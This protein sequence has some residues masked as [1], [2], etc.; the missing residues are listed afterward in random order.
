MRTAVEWIITIIAAIIIYIGFLFLLPIGAYADEYVIKFYKGGQAV[1]IEYNGVIHAFGRGEP[2]KDI[3][4][5]SYI[6]SDEDCDIAITH[7][8]DTDDGAGT[9]LTVHPLDVG[10]DRLNRSTQNTNFLAW[11]HRF[12]F[13]I[14][15]STT[16]KGMRPIGWGYQYRI[17]RE[18]F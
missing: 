5:K 10:G 9:G 12:K 14:T 1:S 3:D 16:A 18:D 8:A 11:S 7:Y 15:T 2:E 17:E 6:Q 4:E 13:S